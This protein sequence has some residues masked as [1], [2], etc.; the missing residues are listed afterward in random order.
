MKSF[1]ALLACLVLGAGVVGAQDD[2]PLDWLGNYKE[3][4]KVARET[5]KPIFLEF[6]CE[7]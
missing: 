6:R 5:G 7:A 3:A 2:Q 4:L 1:R